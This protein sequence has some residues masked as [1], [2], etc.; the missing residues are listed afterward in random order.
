MFAVV[1]F[2]PIIEELLKASGALY[3]AEQRPWLVPRAGSL[4]VI[5]MAAAVAFASIENVLYLT[6]YIDDP[7][8][9][10]VVWRWTVATSLHVA[11][12]MI[13][14]IGVA[15]MWVRTHRHG[16]APDMR[17]ARPWLAAAAIVHG[18][19]NLAVTIAELTDV[20]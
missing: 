12:S 5:T 10:I 11:A 1:L 19:Y 20:I 4:V 17:H 14:G 15:R 6:V 8:P 18:S 13:A 9:F 7:E 16:E 3:L 2:G